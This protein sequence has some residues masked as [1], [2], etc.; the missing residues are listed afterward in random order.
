MTR[1]EKMITF[2]LLALSLVIFF[3][4]VR[5]KAEPQP[6]P[7]WTD[8][9]RLALGQ[10]VMGE[11]D[12][13]T[14]REAAAIG[15]VLVKVWR[16]RYRRFR[17]S[18]R[19]TIRTYCAAFDERGPNYYRTRTANIRNSTW[20]NPLHK[21]SNDPDWS[22]LREFTERFAAQEIRDPCPACIGWV[23]ETD[24]IPPTWTVIMGPPKYKNLFCVRAR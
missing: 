10:C 16:E 15:Y 12:Y 21:P 11:I 20:D 4:V 3:F 2:I 23:G 13:K 5:A 17:W 7:K 24:I 19:T 8:E 9:S 22:E 14:E 18:M 1:N 6:W